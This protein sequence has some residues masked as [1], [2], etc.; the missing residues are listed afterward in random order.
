MGFPSKIR[1]DIFVK[2]ARH[3]CVCHR[4]KG[5]KVEIHHILPKKQGG[6]DTFENAISLCFDCHSDAGHYFAGHPKGSK[7]SPEEL[8]KHKNEWFRIVQEHQIESSNLPNVELIIKDGHFEPVFIKEV[9]KFVDKNIFR[10]SAKLL[11]KDS[12][13]FFDN[14][15]EDNNFENNKKFIPFYYQYAKDYILDNYKR[16]PSFKET[17]IEIIPELFFR[18]KDNTYTLHLRDYV[19]NGESFGK[20]LV[21]VDG[22]LL[23]DV[24]ELFDYNTNNIYKISTI[25]KPYSYGS[26]IF[27]GVVSIITF[28]KEYESKSN[29]IRP[30]TLE[31]CD[32]EKDFFPVIY[33]ADN[34]YDRIPD[35]RYQIAWETNLSLKNNT[36]S[37]EFYTSDISGKFEIYMEGFSLNGEPLSIKKYFTVD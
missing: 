22:L 13:D 3:C 4:Y 19:T 36:N 37:I 25:N 20:P 17:I 9:T 6:E 28:N 27:S 30:I 33:E 32:T 8:L 34:T 12:L 16:F 26:K 2:S 23:Q 5:I 24:N 11:G 15:K 31:R 21:M 29:K 1:E 7:F 10:S 14:L 35:Y 18:Q